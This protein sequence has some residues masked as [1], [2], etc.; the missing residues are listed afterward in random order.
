[1]PAR[2]PVEERVEDE[3]D[4]EVLLDMA[5]HGVETA[6][7]GGEGV[8]P[9][10]F[11]QGEKGREGVLSPGTRHGHG[12]PSPAM[13]RASVS[14]QPGRSRPFR[15]RSRFAASGRRRLR[16][17]TTRASRAASGP[18]Q[19]RA[20]TA[21]AAGRSAQRMTRGPAWRKRIVPPSMPTVRVAPSV[22]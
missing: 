21:A 6:C 12:T 4:P 20:W 18:S 7:R 2:Q 13:S 17:E 19:R 11:R 14:A 5:R 15:A 3:A 1:M 22:T 16:A 8:P 9:V 10:T